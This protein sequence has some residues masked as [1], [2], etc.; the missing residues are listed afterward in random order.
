MLLGG[1][2]IEMAF[3][4]PQGQVESRRL[5]IELLKLQTDAFA[6]RT[7]AHAGGIETLHLAEYALDLHDVAIELRKEAVPD[8]FQAV[9]E[10]AIVIDGIDH[11]TANRVV[12]WLESRKLEL[13]RQVLLQ[14]LCALI[15]EFL[16]AIFV[17]TPGCLRRTGALFCPRVVGDLDFRGCVSRTSAVCWGLS[18]AVAS[19]LPVAVS[20]TSSSDSSITLFSSASRM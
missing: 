8:L 10:I 7:R 16:G 18:V 14:G 5:R 1:K 11:G 19:K 4:N 9:G 17:S 12:A 20:G 2:L 6:D 3:R 15:G 13:P